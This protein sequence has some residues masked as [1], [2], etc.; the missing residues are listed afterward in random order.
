MKPIYN[1]TVLLF[2]FFSPSLLGRTTRFAINNFSP[3]KI[4]VTKRIKSSHSLITFIKYCGS[5]FII[6]QKLR[7][8]SNYWSVMQAILA[9][10][11]AHSTE[12]VPSQRVRLIPNYVNF[13]TKLHKDTPAAL[14]TI[15][16]GKSIRQWHRTSPRQI[17]A[18]TKRL[19]KHL[20]MKQSKGMN[21]RILQSITRHP[22]LSHI[23]ALH[24]ILGFYDGHDGNIFYDQQ[25][26]RFAII[27]MDS[28]FKENLANGS[29]V[30]L[31][32]YFM[33]KKISP[34][35]KKA[36]LIV[37]D[38]LEL[39]IQRNSI[40]KIKEVAIEIAHALKST[41]IEGEQQFKKRIVQV[42][43]FLKESYESAKKLIY[44]IKNGKEPD[45]II[46]KRTF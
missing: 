21:A 4:I 13:P 30:F 44:L 31:K 7:E 1:P 12:T 9:D 5:S 42:E 8:H 28:S 19:L 39:L 18:K 10:V 34:D 25:T 32:K 46:H 33:K 37:A 16:S 45:K 26:N 15:I 22:D 23:L 35:E 40:K 24:I 41:E 20:V 36:L 17:T 6:K 14:L 27:D 43:S 3:E 38:T 29:Y 11:F 2:L